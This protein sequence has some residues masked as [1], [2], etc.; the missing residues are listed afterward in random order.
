M[1]V[2]DIP[3]VITADWLLDRIRTS[4]NVL[5]D[6]FVASTVSHYLEL[7]LKET[8]NKLIK[9]EE[10]KEGRGRKGFNNDL[11][12]QLNNPLN[13]SRHHSQDNNTQVGGN[14]YF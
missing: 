10:E 7:K 3:L 8:D 11:K 13:S 2:K 5:G 12:K 14:K 1:P 4:I 6:A 9:N